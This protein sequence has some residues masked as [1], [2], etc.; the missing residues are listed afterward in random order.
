MLEHSEK[1]DWRCCNPWQSAQSSAGCPAYTSACSIISGPISRNLQSRRALC[2]DS[3]RAAWTNWTGTVEGTDRHLY[4]PISSPQY[5][6]HW[7]D[8]H[9]ILEQPTTICRTATLCF[10]QSGVPNTNG[11]F[12]TPVRKVWR[13][14]SRFSRKSPWL[15]TFLWSSLATFGQ[16]VKERRK[17]KVWFRRLGQIRHSL[18]PL[19]KNLCADRVVMRTHTEVTGSNSF[20]LLNAMCQWADVWRPHSCV[21]LRLESTGMWGRAVW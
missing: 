11:C 5:E 6:L 2:G 9:E 13:H 12:F 19:F 15:S 20:R 14:L 3:Q 17:Y 4:T 1:K 7:A 21:D 8:F 10:T 18:R 16:I